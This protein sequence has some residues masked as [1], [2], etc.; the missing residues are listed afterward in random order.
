M[1]SYRIY[2]MDGVHRIR[3]GAW[4]EAL[5]DEDARRKAAELCDGDTASIEVWQSTRPVG[6]VECHEGHKAA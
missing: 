1:R 4:I 3:R 6:E 5:D 2:W